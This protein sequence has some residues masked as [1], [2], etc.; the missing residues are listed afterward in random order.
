MRGHPTASR[1]AR[2][3][4]PRTQSVMFEWR[5]ELSFYEKRFE[6]LRHLEEERSMWAFRT[7]ENFAEA[8]LIDQWHQLSIRQDRATMHLLSL[9]PYADE[10]WK[11]LSYAVDTIEP[12]YPSAMAVSFQYLAPLDL[13]FDVA[14]ARGY[15][16]VLARVEADGIRGADWAVLMDLELEGWPGA[17]GQTEFGIVEAVEVPRRLS[18]V[19]GRTNLAEAATIP[20]NLWETEEFPPVALFADVTFRTPV[21]SRLAGLADLRTFWES[22]RDRAGNLVA[23]LKAKL[24]ADDTSEEVAS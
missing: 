22:A 20:P 14:V 12:R 2:V 21:E 3:V 4:A 17:I 9:A 5:P 24:V 16:R 7:G 8:R 6:I 13:T 11:A 15:R 23:A 18:R 1:V 19:A 10:T